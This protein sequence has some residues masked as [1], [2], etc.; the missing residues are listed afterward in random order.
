M[1]LELGA[2][3]RAGGIKCRLRK[4]VEVAGLEFGSAQNNQETSFMAIIL[5]AKGKQ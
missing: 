2:E 3:G 5:N 1:Y 4:C